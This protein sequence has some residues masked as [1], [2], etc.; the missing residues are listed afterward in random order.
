MVET[1]VT[2]VLIGIAYNDKAKPLLRFQRVDGDTLGESLAFLVDKDTK[3]IRGVG[4]VWTMK[5][6]TEGDSRK[7]GV[8]GAKY[9]RLWPD[10]AQRLQWD[11]DQKVRDMEHDAELKAKN[12][13]DD[14]P[15]NDMLTELRGLY[16]AQ[17]GVNRSRF[18][19]YIVKE[20][21]K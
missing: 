21:V 11:A 6:F 12:A 19:A 1:L 10:E 14:S 7:W 16:R 9:E 4:T 5:E 2:V 17:I 13:G 15:L 3:H 20:I 8:A 18:L